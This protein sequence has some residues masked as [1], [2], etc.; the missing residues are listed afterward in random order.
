MTQE[1]FS[2]VSVFIEINVN[3]V[4]QV[5][6]EEQGQEVESIRSKK[7]KNCL[8]RMVSGRQRFFLKSKLCVL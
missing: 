3:C 8:N 5:Q 1:E 6:A 7:S 2:S 4:L